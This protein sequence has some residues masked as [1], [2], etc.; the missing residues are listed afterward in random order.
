MARDITMA[1]AFLL[2]SDRTFYGRLIE[3]IENPY[4]QGEYK[5]PNTLIYP[6]KLL[7]NWNQDARNSVNIFREEE[8]NG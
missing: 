1:Y 6:Y 5:Y 7:V 3:V 4:T 8:N 2:I